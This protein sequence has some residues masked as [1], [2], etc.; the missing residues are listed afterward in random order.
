MA[1]AVVPKSFPNIEGEDVTALIRLFLDLT[2][3]DNAILLPLAKG[4]AGT[5]EGAVSEWC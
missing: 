5:D 2:T 3:M 4:Q 1:A